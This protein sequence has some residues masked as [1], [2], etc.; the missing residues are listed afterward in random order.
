MKRRTRLS[1]GRVPIMHASAIVVSGATT[2]DRSAGAHSASAATHFA[3][4][5][6]PTSACGV[7]AAAKTA[8]TTEY[9]FV[10][11]CP[12]SVSQGDRCDAD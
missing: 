4:R 11:S 6:A 2:G 10:T 1:D 12:A 8:T 9:A 5:S 7:S 3:S